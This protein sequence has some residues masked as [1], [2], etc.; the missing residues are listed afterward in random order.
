MF[1]TYE[2]A[3]TWIHGRLRLGMKPGLKRM[4]W[5]LERLNHPERRIRSVHIGGTN[6]KG[7]TTSFLRSILQEA[8]YQIGTF[9]SPYIETFNERIS[10]NGT[11]ISDSEIVELANTIKPLADELEQ[12]ELGG[13]TEFEI[14]TAMAIYYFGKLQPVDLVL[15]EVGLGGRHDS[16][17]VIHPLLTIITNI[18]YDH[19]QILGPTLS[20]IAFEKAGIIKNGVP[21]ITAVHQEEAIQV[22]RK[23]ANEKK[24][25]LYKLGEHFF[26]SNYEPSESGERFSFS[27]DYSQFEDLTLSMIGKH[28]TENA[29]L[30]IM[31]AIYLKTFYAF[32]IEEDQI[33][34]G[35]QNMYWPGRF[36]VLQKSPAL[37]I[38]GAHNPEGIDRLIESL[39]LH[40]PNKNIH[41]LFSALNDK[42]LK[43]MIKKLDSV[44]YTIAF[45]EIS[46]PRATKAE[47]LYH[48][49]ESK[50]KRLVLDWKEYLSSAL[51]EISEEDIL[52]VTGSLYFISEVKQYMK[53]LIVEI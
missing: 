10:I 18:G 2:E 49:S 39:K 27:S 19:T 20:H 31:A 32:I 38:D 8:G 43:D 13:P 25:L 4:E 7:S 23:V 46:A 1:Q 44:A 36:E 5:M 26:I 50:N 40:Y 6:G 29:S 47:D 42:K 9:T 33:R 14:I 45:T 3:L 48:L 35:L 11:P 24:S 52:M 30:A 15:F 51:K 41:F 22:I 12:T 34:T 28:Q 37:V 21:V 16:T 53:N 17:N